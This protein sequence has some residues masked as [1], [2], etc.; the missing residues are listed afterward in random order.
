MASV[1]GFVVR[2]GGIYFI[3]GYLESQGKDRPVGFLDSG[4]PTMHEQFRILERRK[5]KA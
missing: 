5:S 1:L 3:F 2:V 4:S